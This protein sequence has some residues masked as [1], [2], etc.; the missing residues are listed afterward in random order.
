MANYRKAAVNSRHSHGPPPKTK[1][2][3]P[4]VESHIREACEA[5][6]VGTC[7]NLAK[8]AEEFDVPYTTMR[9]RFQGEHVP[10]REA[11]IKE[12]LLSPAQEEVMVDWMKFLGMVGRPVCQQT[13]RP[14]VHSLCGKYPGDTWVRRF[15][16]RHPEVKL[17]RASNLDP[18]R[19]QAFNFT[20]VN[21]YFEKL[22]KIM[23]E[24]EIPWENVYNMDEKGIQLGGGRK[25]S[26]HKYFWLRRDRAQY[27]LRS[28]NLELVTIVESCCADGSSFYPGFI[29]AGK[30]IDEESTEVHPD[31]W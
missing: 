11:H 4:E 19:A 6:C 25:T 3:T 8:A 10:A 2:V 12:M 20:S 22:T 23:R 16:K 14:K 13:M 31:I 1:V 18:K 9:N 15:I 24:K 27:K 29:F 7:K 21:D 30:T 5:L 17:G 28:A 26:R